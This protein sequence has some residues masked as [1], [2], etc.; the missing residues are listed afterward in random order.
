[1]CWKRVS[2][3]TSQSGKPW[4]C[5]CRPVGTALDLD[6]AALVQQEAAELV[7]GIAADL[8]PVRTGALGLDIFQGRLQV[9]SRSSCGVWLERQAQDVP[10]HGD[11]D[12][13]DDLLAGSAAGKP[14]R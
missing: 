14:V 11:V 9:V 7:Q 6:L 1:M 5:G 4:V 3:S 2:S 8:G 12:G 13:A 10:G